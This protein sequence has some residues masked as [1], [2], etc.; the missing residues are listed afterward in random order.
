MSEELTNLL[1]KT[2]PNE[3][4]IGDLWKI[5]NKGDSKVEL[6]DKWVDIPCE[7]QIDIVTKA[8]FLETYDNVGFGVYRVLLAIGGFKENPHGFHTAGICFSTLYY[9]KD[10]E[11]ITLDFHEEFR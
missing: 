4:I 3:K 7:T 11:L 9:D 1:N 10:G 2:I 6:N 5:L 8:Y